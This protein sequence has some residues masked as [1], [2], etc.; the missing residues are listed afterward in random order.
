MR[1]LGA[2]PTITDQDLADVATYIRNEWTNKAPPVSLSLVQ[3]QR[4]ATRHRGAR[5]WTA[6]E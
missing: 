1:A 2:N 4:Q 3:Q 5:A 6:E